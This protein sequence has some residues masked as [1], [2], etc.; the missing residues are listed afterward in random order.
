MKK[1]FV[2]LL[3]ALLP[4]SLVLTATPAPAQSIFGVP[5]AEGIGG[6]A[7]AYDAVDDDYVVAS[8]REVSPLGTALFLDLVQGTGPSRA[9]FSASWLDLKYSQFEVVAVVPDEEGFA[10]FVNHYGTQTE[11][12]TSYVVKIS[13]GFPFVLWSKKLTNPKNPESGFVRVR[14]AVYDDG[15]YAVVGA[16][17]NS[18]FGA[19]TFAALLG[20]DGGLSWIRTYDFDLGE[21]SVD[22]ELLSVVEADGGG[23]VVGGWITDIKSDDIA[24][25]VMMRLEIHG[26][27]VRAVHLQNL[28]ANFTLPLMSAQGVPNTTG[29]FYAL[30]KRTSGDVTFLGTNTNLDALSALSVSV[31]GD[32]TPIDADFVGQGSAAAVLQSGQGP[33][34]HLL[35]LYTMGYSF[36]PPKLYDFNALGG[37]SNVELRWVEANSSKALVSGTGDVPGIFGDAALMTWTNSLGQLKGCVPA[38]NKYQSFGRVASIDLDVTSGS[39]TV[40]TVDEPLYLWSHQ[41]TFEVSACE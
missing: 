20:P 17:D 30:G 29:G 18:F 27:S 14:Q 5:I 7:T 9:S 3:A 31:G 19:E 10:V 24:E 34:R 41:S 38:E 4:V 1:T 21:T 39:P 32:F 35:Q 11:L 33:A 2:L 12:W 23:F 40:V 28:W 36:F 15:A 26:N 37:A 8:I 22:V 25:V 6:Q 13:R 16:L